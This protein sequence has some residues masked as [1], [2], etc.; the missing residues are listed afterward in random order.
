MPLKLK[1]HVK[2]ACWKRGSTAPL[3]LALGIKWRL[4]AGIK[5]EY[6]LR[7]SKNKVR[8]RILGPK[9]EDVT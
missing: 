3:I 2:R 4:V 7:V 6:G 9:W 5:K 1:E 8:R